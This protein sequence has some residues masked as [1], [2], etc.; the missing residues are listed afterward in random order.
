[1]FDI[2]AAASNLLRDR[3]MEV[4]AP[5]GTYEAGRH[6]ACM[7]TA[8]WLGSCNKLEASQE[9]P[10]PGSQTESPCIW[11]TNP[12]PTTSRAPSG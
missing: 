10:Y 2:H 7:T 12:S 9:R 8:G 6:I 11:A 4:V 1:M 5:A 3:R